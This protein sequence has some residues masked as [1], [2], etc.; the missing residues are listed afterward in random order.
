MNEE[1]TVLIEIKVGKKN[2]TVQVLLPSSNIDANIKI[3][4][5]DLWND[6]SLIKYA[7]S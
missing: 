1:G 5:S 7:W 2:H 4:A 3:M 6:T